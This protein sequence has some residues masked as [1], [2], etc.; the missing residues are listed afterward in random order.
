MNTD[1]TVVSDSNWSG[2][3]RDFLRE[4]A[5]GIRSFGDYILEEEIARGGMGIVYRA[6]QISLDRTVAVKVMKEGLFAAGR[7]VER[8]RQEAS[9][10]A[11]L[12]HP[13]IVPVFESGE[14]EGRFFYAMEWIAGPNLAEVTRAHPAAAKQAAQWVREV[15]E[16]MQHAHDHGVV[17]R[18]L[19]PA[20]VMLDSEGRT[21]VTDFGMAQ[22]ADTASGLTLSGQM[23]GTPG[24]MAPEVA[25]G[26]ARTA[27]AAADI[28]GLGAIL[29]HLLTGRAPF[30]GES[31]SAILKQL[32]ES[33][34]VSLR[35]L[36]ASVPRDLETICLK[37]LQRDP[38][39]RYDS[40]MSLAGDLG[41][42]LD[43]HPVLARP[44]SAAE[45]MWRWVR[46]RPA[47]AAALGACI[48]SISG[49]LGVALWQWRQAEIARGE[50]VQRAT[51]K[52]EQ[53]LL[54]ERSAEERRV[55]LYAADMP[56]VQQALADSNFPQMLRLLD[57]HRPAP[58][59][60]DLRGWEWRYF[61]QQTR[62]EEFAS[63]DGGRRALTGLAYSPDGTRLAVGGKTVTVWDAA[64]LALLKK[65][66]EL[67]LTS[68]AWSPDG[69]TLY[70]GTVAKRL[71]R[72]RWQ[73]QD[74]LEKLCETAEDFVR[75][76]ASPGGDLLAV[77]CGS[78]MAGDPD[79]TVTLHDAATGEVRRTLPESGGF[80]SFSPDGTLLAT[81]SW[82]GAVKLW[83]PATGE[84]RRTLMDL[85]EATSLRFSRDGRQLAVSRHTGECRL[86]EVATGTARS[87]NPGHGA[88]VWDAELSPDGMQLAIGGSVWDAITGRQTAKFRGRSGVLVAWAADGKS[89]AT[90]GGDGTVRF[91]RPGDSARGPERLPV[92]VTPR[93]FS[94]DGRWVV[95]QA[96]D[97]MACL[98]A[99]PS[100]AKE[101]EA[102]VSYVLGFGP[103]GASPALLSYGSFGKTGGPR[104][105][106]HWSL[107]DL[108]LVK[109][110]AVPGTEGGDEHIRLSDD[111]LWLTGLNAAG[112]VRFWNLA[113][114]ARLTDMDK[115]I[116]NR[117]VT[118]TV[119]SNPPLLVAGC[120][121]S[122]FLRLFAL[123]S[124]GFRGNLTL[125]QSS[126]PAAVLLPDAPG[127]TFIV[128][129]T[130]SVIRKWDV[131][132]RRDLWQI[133][134]GAGPIALSPDGL[135]LASAGGTGRT[136]RLWHLATRREVARFP[137]ERKIATMAFAPD[138]GALFLS[139]TGSGQP[140]STLVLRA[141]DFAK[142]DGPAA[143]RVPK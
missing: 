8:F 135:T 139:E 115:R 21:R 23:L 110:V 19:K 103:E 128:S 55:S 129:S 36:N 11:A 142:T 98:H 100:L 25:G 94:R 2:M 46:R 96:A 52:E 37:A 44:V 12:Q 9:A 124:G 87:G 86:I 79:G 5:P 41:R 104:S 63:L 39:R 32:A 42:F 116:Y 133:E 71:L 30:I 58:G 91:W 33:E 17:H 143:N 117:V 95:S 80:P 56:Q 107:P 138:G 22:R 47:L 77:G 70:L 40:A 109:T 118:L 15:A 126:G 123:P 48:I 31:H 20:N 114:G 4:P 97:G 51:E 111:G 119:L 134:E 121:A 106:G 82:R 68:L 3:A 137:M 131:P 113:D 7:E 26:N 60:T 54:A 45:R 101:G 16:A 43:G 38:H 64:T 83:D 130:D 112:R 102:H 57:A 28:Y 105:V 73:D 66:P 93:S 127:T 27:G 34:P 14:H 136:V 1:E 10:A 18:D 29:F 88:W 13:G 84:V 6:Q 53:R 67:D 61:W 81:G 74:L 65:S 122:P 35:L 85:P 69:Q 99:Y 141:P 140:D 89:V 125:N 59:Q 76:A 108:K 62:G 92:R 49:G 120:D 72:W 132:A 90:G 75:V 50:A 78:R 24:Y